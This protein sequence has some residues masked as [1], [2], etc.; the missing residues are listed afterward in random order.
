VKPWFLGKLDFSPPVNDLAQAG[1]P[2]TGGRL[3]YVAGRVVAALV[4]TA[5]Q[6]TINVS[7]GRRRLMPSVRRTG[8]LFADFTYDTGPRGAY[9]TGRCP[10]STTR[11]STSSSTRCSC[12]ARNSEPDHQPATLT[13]CWPHRTILGM[14]K[15]RVC[16]R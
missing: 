8:R 13:V 12:S 4:Y 14:S 10:M 16:G 1:F 9:P 3:D 5:G 11:N 6:H 2:L 7:C 15:A